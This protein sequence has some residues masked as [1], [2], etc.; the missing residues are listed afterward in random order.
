MAE[1]R[2]C[3]LAAGSIGA[4]VAIPSDSNDDANTRG[5][6]GLFAEFGAS[7]YLGP[8]GSPFYVGGGVIPRLFF[9]PSDGGVMAAF[10]VQAGYMFMRTSST[11]LYV[12]LRV[13]QN[14]MPVR[15]GRSYDS[16]TGTTVV[17]DEP[18]TIYPTELGVQVG[19]GW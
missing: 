19:I 8:L 1:M 6:G 16:Y 4:G 13:A 18:T 3:S 7:A 5:Y 2:R 10:Y 14:A 11:R 15:L 17:R 12:E 9:G